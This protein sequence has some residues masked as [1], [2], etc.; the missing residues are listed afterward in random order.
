MTSAAA[1]HTTGRSP[2]ENRMQWA[3]LWRSYL[4]M[5][6]CGNGDGFGGPEV[7]TGDGGRRGRH[8]DHVGDLAPSPF[9]A[10][11]TALPASG[12]MPGTS[13]AA[14]VISGRWRGRPSDAY[15]PRPPSQTVASASVGPQRPAEP[16][17][18]YQRR[19]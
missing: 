11:A 12:V 16:S 3:E 10:S 5:F 1:D 14:Y 6:G 4:F 7:P 15:D 9:D 13:G 8:G 17:S 19:E 18:P 2:E